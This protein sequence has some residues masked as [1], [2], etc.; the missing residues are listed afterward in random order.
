MIFLCIRDNIPFGSL[1]VLMSDCSSAS[2]V[3]VPFPLK[4]GAY[5]DARSELITTRNLTVK[6]ELVRI[7]F[8]T[9]INVYER[10]Q[11]TTT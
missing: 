1:S 3:R 2:L 5:I 11:E 9:H 8:K 6:C 10:A 7:A 4:S